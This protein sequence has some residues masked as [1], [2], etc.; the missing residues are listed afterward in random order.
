[1]K[2]WTCLALLLLGASCDLDTG[3]PGGGG[4]AINFLKGYVFIRKDD[5]NVY[6]ADASDLNT[7]GKLS[8]GGGARHPSLSRDGKKVVFVQSAGGGTDL[9]AVASNGATSPTVIL[10][11]T[12]T[13]KNFRFPVF[14]PDGAKIVFAYDEGSASVLGVVNADGSG[15]AKLAG[16]PTLSY[17]SPSFYADGKSVLAAAGNATNGYTQLEKIAV[18]TGTPTSVSSSIPGVKAVANR[19]VLSPDGTKVAL[20]GRPSGA[21]TGG[22]RIFVFTISGAQSSQLTDYPADPSAVDSFPTW[23]G[24]DKV[25]FS[26]DTGGSDKLYSLS[27]T[28]VKGSGGFQ[29]PNAIEPWFGP[30]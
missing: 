15:F 11:S 26:S 4:G 30:N 25:G 7:T 19:A 22:D 24:N 3:G 9:M 8:S 16:G 10:S 18:D 14:S 1:M 5:L 27:A 29:L 2:R 6:L 17:N 13:Q 12:A 23:V 20:D 21:G 28:T